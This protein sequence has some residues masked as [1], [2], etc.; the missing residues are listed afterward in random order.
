MHDGR[1]FLRGRKHDWSTARENRAEG[2]EKMPKIEVR[3]R[4]NGGYEESEDSFHVHG[5]SEVVC[6][7]THSL[8]HQGVAITLRALN[9]VEIKLLPSKQRYV[10]STVHRIF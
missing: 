4:G 6:R 9:P 2:V 8:Q 5:D 3:E 10:T 1:G 7:K